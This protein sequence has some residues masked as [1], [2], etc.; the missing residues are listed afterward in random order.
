MTKAK[1][2]DLK[3]NEKG[4]IDL[5]KAFSKNIRR[6][7]VE[8]V[9]E[10]RKTEQ[11]FSPSPVGGKQHSASGVLVHR[12]HVWKSQYGRGM[13]RVPRKA[14][15]NKGSQFNWVGAEVPNTRG[16]RRAHPPKVLSRMGQLKINKK[17]M[18]IALESALAATTKGKILQE[19]YKTLKNIKVKDLPIIVDSII[20]TK[21]TKEVLESL[22]NILGEDLYKVAIKKKSVRSGRGKSR[23]RKYKST[24]GLLLVQGN[25]EKLKV[26]QVETT[27]V[28]A[29]NVTD[30]AKG[31]LGRLTIYTE[32]AIK[33]LGEKLK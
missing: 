1:I 3:G 28:N 33:E 15:S 23:G 12:R 32:E 9:L 24:A 5:P 6:D 11:P 25:K 4:T 27:K 21:K 10:A 16:G 18:R 22:K 17:E 7:M 13:S 20:T 8:K 26:S 19:K 14:M 2:R 31:G 30:L 29:L